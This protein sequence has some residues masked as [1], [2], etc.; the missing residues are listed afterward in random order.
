MATSRNDNSSYSPAPVPPR[1]SYYIYRINHNTGEHVLYYANNVPEPCCALHDQRGFCNLWMA[2]RWFNIFEAGTV[3]A[4]NYYIST[5]P[6]PD[7]NFKQKLGVTCWQ[8]TQ[9]QID[10]NKRESERYRQPQ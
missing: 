5:S 2:A 4:E 7:P 9:E 1:P 10:Q 3:L 6:Q 8:L